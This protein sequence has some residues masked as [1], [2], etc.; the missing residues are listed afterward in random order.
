MNTTLT[1]R[2]AWMGMMCAFG[3]AAQGQQNAAGIRLNP[4]GRLVAIDGVPVSSSHPLHGQGTTRV[5]RASGNAESQRVA[6]AYYSSRNSPTNIAGRLVQSN[7]PFSHT[8]GN[9]A[10]E[11]ANAERARYGQRPLAPD[12]H[13]Q[14]LALQKATAAARRGYKNHIGGSLGGAKCEGVGHAN[15]RFLSCC[16]NEP[17]TYG[18]AAMVQGADGWYCCLLVR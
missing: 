6:Y 8:P 10:L 15:G 18:G 2:I 17:G 11:K 16:L 3:A 14:A 9:T 7:M 4:G 1:K 12:P 5:G 13:L